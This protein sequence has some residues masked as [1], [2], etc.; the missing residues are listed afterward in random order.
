VKERKR[1]GQKEICVRDT[2]KSDAYMKRERE[3][4]RD[5]KEEKE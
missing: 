3:K 2:S 5:V 1:E 4:E